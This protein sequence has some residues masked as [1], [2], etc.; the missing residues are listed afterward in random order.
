MFNNNE[1]IM[2]KIIMKK[3]MKK[4]VIGECLSQKEIFHAV[5]FAFS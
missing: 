2:K 3:I 4:G 5:D 1:E